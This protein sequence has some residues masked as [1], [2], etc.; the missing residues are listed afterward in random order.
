MIDGPSEL[1]KSIMW[2]LQYVLDKEEHRKFLKCGVDLEMTLSVFTDVYT[3][4]AVSDEKIRRSAEVL[5]NFFR[6]WYS[7][8]LCLWQADSAFHGR[9][10]ATAV[11]RD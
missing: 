2:T 7:L 4:N 11:R 9:I 10:I 6:S 1:L 5:G 8:F 3:K